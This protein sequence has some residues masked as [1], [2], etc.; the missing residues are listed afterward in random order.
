MHVVE[1][2]G[3]CLD[4]FVPQ[5]PLRSLDGEESRHEHSDGRHFLWDPQSGDAEWE[6]VAESSHKRLLLSA[7][8]GSPL[9]SA[10]SRIRMLPAIYSATT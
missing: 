1:Q 7:D 10:S 3:C 9:Y 6:L 5:L 4:E 8:E 2:F